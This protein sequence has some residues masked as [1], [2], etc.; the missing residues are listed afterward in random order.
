M[1]ETISAHHGV[2]GAKLLEKWKYAD[3]YIAC[4][5]DHED[6][7]ADMDE[8][9]KE[10][11]PQE[12]LIVR[13]AN[14]AAKSMGYSLEEKDYSDLAIENI[15]SAFDLKLNLIAINKIKEK[16]PEEMKGVM[17]LF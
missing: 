14:M 6:H 13:F 1:I 7:E 4:A 5:S 8:E 15:E 3:I 16:V 17:E 12:I 11:L 10:T 9:Q 2:V